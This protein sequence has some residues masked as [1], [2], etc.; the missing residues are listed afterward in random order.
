MTANQEDR[1]PAATS[2]PAN[3]QAHIDSHWPTWTLAGL[4][5]QVA[6]D[7]IAASYDDAVRFYRKVEAEDGERTLRE[8]AAEALDAAGWIPSTVARRKS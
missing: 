2:D 8:Y 6:T 4:A 1:M 7:A 5:C 3:I